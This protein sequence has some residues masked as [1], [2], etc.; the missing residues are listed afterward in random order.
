MLTPPLI[1][2]SRGPMTLDQI[3]DY[4]S[5]RSY[6]FQRESHPRISAEMWKKHFDSADVDRWEA[7]YLSEL[8][9]IE[10]LM[11]MTEGIA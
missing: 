9:V 6:K 10:E 1:Q 11:Q 3:G 5:Y 8:G 2:T 7:R 4:L